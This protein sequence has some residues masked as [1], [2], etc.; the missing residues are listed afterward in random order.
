M[1]AGQEDITAFVKEN[2]LL[3]PQ[4]NYDWTNRTSSPRK[5]VIDERYPEI[6]MTLFKIGVGVDGRY[7]YRTISQRTCK[8][9]NAWQLWQ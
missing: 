4:L 8:T 9:E 6:E 5:I 1:E 2:E 7:V 3:Q